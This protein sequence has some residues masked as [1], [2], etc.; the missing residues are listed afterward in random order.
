M[1]L[2]ANDM[3][4]ELVDPRTTRD[5]GGGIGRDELIDKRSRY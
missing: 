1:E 3:S 4:A 5:R 2:D